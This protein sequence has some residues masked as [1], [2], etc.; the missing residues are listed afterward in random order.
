VAVFLRSTGSIA[1]GGVI[2][3]GSGSPVVFS[4]PQVEDQK[5]LAEGNTAKAILVVAALSP[6]TERI[7]KIANAEGKMVDAKDV[8]GN[9]I[10]EVV[11]RAI[12]KVQ[13]VSLG[14]NNRVT[15]YENGD[16]Y[17]NANHKYTEI[18]GFGEPLVI[19][20]IKAGAIITSTEGFY[21]FSE[22]THRA[23][24]N[25][26]DQW[27]NNYDL[28]DQR[29]GSMPLM[30]MAMS[31]RK[32]VVFASGSSQHS[33][34]EN[35]YELNQ[36]FHGQ[37]IICNGFEKSTVSFKRRTWNASGESVI[38]EVNGQGPRDL[39]PF[40]ITYFYTHGNEEYL[41]ES[42]SEV[43]GCI[44]AKMGIDPQ[45]SIHS[46]VP[47]TA[48]FQFPRLIMP[49]NNDLLTW[50]S[51]KFTASSFDGSD[52]I[53]FRRQ[54]G[55]RKE[56]V[57]SPYSFSD[58]NNPDSFY[59]DFKRE[60]YS[61]N[62]AFRLKSTGTITSTTSNDMD[63]SG[64]TPGIPVE[65][66]SQIV[67]Q[68]LY[69]SNGGAPKHSSISILSLE[70]GTAYCYEWS[71]NDKKSVLKYT[72]PLKKGVNGQG[73]VTLPEIPAA[74][75]LVSEWQKNNVSEL[76]ND[77]A[78]VGMSGRALRPG[79]IY[80]DVPIAVIV[81]N[82]DVNLRIGTRQTGGGLTTNIQARATEVTTFGITPGY[83]KPEYAMSIDGTQLKRVIADNGSVKFETAD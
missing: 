27:G 25:H 73:N 30:S 35:R 16:D 72:I 9:Y 59:V 5:E 78:V 55:R 61:P 33:L 80:A 83:V 81:Q 43:M 2:S 41:I 39:E 23:K 15:V 54:G 70:E 4:S 68:P 51:T 26:T 76:K 28:Y 22:Q 29:D 50:W 24:I 57:I 40:E 12:T 60:G 36:V 63:G 65:M 6:A 10:F 77:T 18:L 21:G 32:T 13:G 62:S 17:L 37:V 82:G 52:F 31:F 1:T 48:C 45:T 49:V 74:G 67:A 71:Q 7:K 20:D 34:A 38:E 56:S 69:I 58:Q 3:G 64:S 79:Y 8:N 11:P 42:T 66:M 53:A 14:W 75:Q 47:R 19:T 44:Q 46:P